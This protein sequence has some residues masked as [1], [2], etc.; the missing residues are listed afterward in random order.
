MQ[1]HWL[2][3]GSRATFGEASQ[4]DAQH[5]R[6]GTLA[7]PTAC[8][9]VN[10]ARPTESTTYCRKLRGLLPK[11]KKETQSRLDSYSQD[12]KDPRRGRWSCA[13][14]LALSL[15][16]LVCLLPFAVCLVSRS[17]PFVL[18]FLIC[19]SF[20]FL[21][22]SSSLFPSSS[23]FLSFLL[24]FL[25]SFF[26]SLPSLLLSFPLLFL[27]FLFVFIPSFFGSTPPHDALVHMSCFSR[28]Q[29]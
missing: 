20:P 18:I 25:P 24:S 13:F 3:P 27:S 15:S 17:F 26:P 1:R 6:G 5:N 14:P 2:N 16:C 29:P 19:P 10:G 4:W 28:P 23:F 7:E 21:F 12:G 9:V 8:A 11:R 22:S